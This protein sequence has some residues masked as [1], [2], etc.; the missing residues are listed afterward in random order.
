MQEKLKFIEDTDMGSKYGA[1]YTEILQRQWT[2]NT[3]V[4][5]TKEIDDTR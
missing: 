3:D 5:V 4:E 2:F 1:I